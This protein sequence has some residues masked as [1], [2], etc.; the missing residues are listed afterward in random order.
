[1]NKALIIIDIQNEYSQEGN[2]PISNFVEVATN[3]SNIDF[4][5]YETI[6]S[7]K[8]INDSG[9]FSEKWNTSY[10][11]ELKIKPDYELIK[12]TADSFQT[13]KLDSILQAN[14]IT[15]LHICGMMTQNCVTYTALAALALNYNVSVLKDLCATID[16]MVNTIALIALE[17]KLS[18]I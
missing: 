13:T 6:I 4:T 12:T 3:V 7:I 2:L 16:P 8:H 1:M 9:I 14:N 17:S 15:D 5:Q 18:L 11:D 10:P